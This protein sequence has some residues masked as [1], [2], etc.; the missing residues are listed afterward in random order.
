M[1]LIEKLPKIM[2]Q[3]RKT[4]EQ[5]IEGLESKQKISLQT[6]EL[7]YPSRDSDIEDIFREAGWKVTY[8]KPAYNESYDAY[9]KFEGKL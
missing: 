6:R 5:I 2:E 7:V 1:S 3:G 4:A 8:D 9:F